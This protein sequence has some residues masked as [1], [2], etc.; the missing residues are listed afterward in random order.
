M[1]RVHC[2][3]YGVRRLG[4]GSATLLLALLSAKLSLRRR[5]TLNVG[6]ATA[7]RLEV[8][9]LMVALVTAEVRPAA[10]CVFWRTLVT[11]SSLTYEML[12]P[13]RTDVLPF[14]NTSQ[15]KPTTGAKLFRSRL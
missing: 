5:G 3:T 12:Y 2:C 8:V 9:P 14:P 10:V 13:P 7:G 11:R 4:S 15:A 6:T 1:P